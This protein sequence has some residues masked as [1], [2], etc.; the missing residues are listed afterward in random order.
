MREFETM[1]RGAEK[2][3]PEVSLVI[4]VFNSA[5]T[6][7]WLVDQVFADFEGVDFEVVLVNDGSTDSSE[8]ACILLTE[9]YPDTVRYVHLARNYGKHAAVLAGLRH[10]NGRYVAVLDDDGQN[11]PDEARRMYEHAWQQDLDVVYGRYEYRKLSLLRRLGSWFDDFTAGLVLEKPRDIHLSSF[12]VMSRMVVE[13]GCQVRRQVPLP[14]RHDLSRHQKRRRDRGDAFVP[15]RRT[16]RLHLSQTCR[17]VDEHVPGLFDGAVAGGIA[18]GGTMSAI[19]ML[20]LAV[21][22]ARAWSDPQLGVSLPSLAACVVT[23]AAGQLIML[24]M[25]CEYLGR[26]YLQQNGTPQYVVRYVKRGATADDALCDTQLFSEQ[27]SS[28]PVY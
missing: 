12:K 1:A 26:C 2:L 24:G 25:L 23:F 5:A 13:R 16:I 11:P 4:P 10:A 14:R 7:A 28:W 9:K 19:A 27:T 17:A 15:P 20:A 6:I 8:G 22:V 21:I 3:R 18:L